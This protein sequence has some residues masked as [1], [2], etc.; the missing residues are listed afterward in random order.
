MNFRPAFFYLC[1]LSTVAPVASAQKAI[2]A[3][4]ARSESIQN[5]GPLLERV[6]ALKAELRQY[7]DCAATAGCYPKDLDQQA[8]RAITF[9]HTRAAQRKSDEK[10]AMVLDI[11]E[12]TL[13]NWAEMDAANFEYIS[14]DFNAWVA[15]A[16]APAIP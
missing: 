8:D 16:Q 11:D 5:L 14:K 7:H 15:S 9:L 6:N 2:T 4:A 10:L 13:S 12:T 1:L 3:P